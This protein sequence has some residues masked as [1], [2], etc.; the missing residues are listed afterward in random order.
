M[1]DLIEQVRL[2]IPFDLPEAQVCR[3]DGC[4]GC[5]LKLL[6]YLET[7]LEGWEQRLAEGVQPNF[8]DLHRLA[9]SARKIH[10]ILSKNG[11]CVPNPEDQDSD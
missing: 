3:A 8:G 2:A 10:R 4:D 9:A 7:E 11:L 5:S 1:R 6:S